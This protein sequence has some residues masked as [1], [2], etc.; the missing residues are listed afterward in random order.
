MSLLKG[1]TPGP[2]KVGHDGTS[3]PII[4]AT[5]HK[6]LS[7]GQFDGARWSSYEEEEADARLIA[8]APDLAR[9]VELLREVVDEVEDYLCQGIHGDST[10][11]ERMA[12][13]Y[14]KEFPKE[15]TDE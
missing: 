9:E 2:W 14:R 8:A 5:G 6:M 12:E 13:D 7:V 15:Q 11:M 1:T 4:L 10:F 3:R